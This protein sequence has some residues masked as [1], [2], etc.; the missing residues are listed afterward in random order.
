MAASL[1]KLNREDKISCFR[2]GTTRARSRRLIQKQITVLTG[3]TV[4]PGEVA[5]YV[6]ARVVSRVTQ[7]RSPLRAGLTIATQEERT[8][9][10]IY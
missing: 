5:K 7:R 10:T 4:N 6:R 8:Q 2:A 1:N 3:S 9:K